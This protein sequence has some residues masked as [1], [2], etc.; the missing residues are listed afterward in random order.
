MLLLDD[1]VLDVDSEVF[2]FQHW[3]YTVTGCAEEIVY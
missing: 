3:R 1:E 2:R